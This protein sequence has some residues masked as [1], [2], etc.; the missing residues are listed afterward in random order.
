MGD[1]KAK[2]T[3]SGE[4]KIK[5]TQNSNLKGLAMFGMVDLV[6]VAPYGK[7]RTVS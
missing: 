2:S 7:Q 4:G 1:Q 6:P 5:V 3:F